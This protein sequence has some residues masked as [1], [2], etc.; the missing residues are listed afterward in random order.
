MRPN[1]RSP[2]HLRLFAYSTWLL[3]ALAG[4]SSDDDI[5]VL[6]TCG[7]GVVE[8]KEECDDG[9]TCLGGLNDGARCSLLLGGE[10]SCLDFD[11]TCSLTQ[12]CVGGST[13]GAFC[14]NDANCCPGD[15]P[16]CGATCVGRGGFC[17][18]G[19]NAGS[20]CGFDADCDDGLCIGSCLGGPLDGDSCT[21]FTQCSLDGVCIIDDT[22][23][24]TSICTT[25]RCGD[26]VLFPGLEQCDSFQ[27]DGRTCLDFGRT[28]G[29]GLRC[30]D[31][32]VFDVS[33]CGPEFTPTPTAT[34]TSNEPTNTP[35]ETPTPTATATPTMNQCDNGLLDSTENTEVEV[36]FFG[37][38][39]LFDVGDPD[40][41]FCAEDGEP[42]PCTPGGD[43]ISVGFELIQPQS[44]AIDTIQAILSYRTDVAIVDGEGTLGGAALRDT[45]VVPGAQPSVLQALEFNVATR[46]V[47]GRTEPIAPGLTFSINM[48]ICDG[49]SPTEADFDCYVESC[50]GGGVPP[51][52]DCLCNVI[53]P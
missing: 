30:D 26:G 8:S 7:N 33:G 35:T 23:S 16:E 41:I 12:T 36:D 32:C 3:A 18:G 24:C 44:L 34:A 46:V 22:D 20:T 47:L 19:S 11:G 17:E 43:M 4:C 5:Q 6:S 1:T 10:D 13:P 14:A 39:M 25:P 42:L 21:S 37:T 45:V 52:E 53:L 28:Q 51:N 31:T 9:G 15:D 27:L 38:P 50:A 2:I 29:D 40:G 49:A 48:E